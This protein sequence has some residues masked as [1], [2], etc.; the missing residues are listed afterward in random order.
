MKVIYDTQTGY[1]QA[2]EEVVKKALAQLIGVNRDTVV[3]KLA[4]MQIEGAWRKEGEGGSHF[5]GPRSMTAYDAEVASW[6]E[7]EF[8]EEVPVSWVPEVIADTSGKWANN[9]VR[10][11][12]KIEAEAYVRDLM[13]RWV[14]V[15]DT[16]V[17][18]SPDAVNYSYADGVLQGI[19]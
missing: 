12:T 15:T 9:A 4:I 7:I 10:F 13:S 3:K 5:S 19:P 1:T 17:V 2:K 6:L 8:P 18:G 16:R 11:A 14:L